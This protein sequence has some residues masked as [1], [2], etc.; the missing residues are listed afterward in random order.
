[1]KNTPYRVLVIDDEQEMRE[2][3]VALLEE[4]NF[5]VE[6]A[7]DGE[8]GLKKLLTDEFD[9]ALVDLQM[10]KMDG[11]TMIRRAKAE[12]VHIPM[13]ILTA[14]GDSFKDALAA[15]NIGVKECFS[16]LSLDSDKLVERLST[17]VQDYRASDNYPALTQL[18]LKNLTSFPEA[19]LALSPQLNIFI[20][21]NATGK[22]HLLKVAYSIL[23]A[24]AELRLKTE[25]KPTET[26]LAT[27]VSD[28]LVRV[29]RAE[30]LGNL[31]RY[32]QTHGEA[33]VAFDDSSYDATF[34]FYS[35]SDKL[36]IPH[37]PEKWLTTKPVFLPPHDLLIIFPNFIT[38]YEN[39][40]LEFE[41]TWR[42]T[43]IALGGLKRRKISHSMQTLLADLET[44]MGGK[45]ELDKNGRFYLNVPERGRLE[46]PLIAEGQRKL[47]ML[48]Q[49]IMTG[50]LPRGYLFWDEP[51]ANLNPRLLKKI[52]PTLLVLCAHGVQVFIAT[53]SLFLLREIEICLA[54]EPYQHL[55]SR[56]F[57]LHK[58]DQVVTIK[59][60][61][62][63]DDV[64]DIAVLDEEL[65][66]SDRFMDSGV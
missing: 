41:E 56:W 47:A 64:G 21:E 55:K 38:V 35:N 50:A 63:V 53:H 30:K 39:Y 17:L 25:E 61:D 43:C 37:L 36:Q 5:A 59:Q 10:P 7:N 33:T 57:G 44:T 49:L 23:A 1:M 52:A 48:A 46:V 66:Q 40:Y 18:T 15:S 12:N 2:E 13:A 3:L 29:F 42:D 54:S 14:H 22:T 51:E 65:A 28:K 8:D 58:Q 45:I 9:V 27:A 60:G 26:E 6:T 32:Q 31:V 11:L 24:N 16:K 34:H 4:H 19:T 62:S 20:G